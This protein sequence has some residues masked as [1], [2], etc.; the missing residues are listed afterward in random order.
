MEK[1]VW[2]LV[3]S[4]LAI[5]S[6]SVDSYFD[7]MKAEREYMIHIVNPTDSLIAYECGF[8]VQLK[9]GYNDNV[10]IAKFMNK[11]ID[12]VEIRYISYYWVDGGYGVELVDVSL[13]P[14]LLNSGESGKVLGTFHVDNGE[15]GLIY[16][17]FEAYWANGSALIS[18][19]FCPVNISIVHKETAWAIPEYCNED[20]NCKCWKNDID[21]CI[22]WGRYFYYRGGD[23][24]VPVYAG[25]HNL[26]GYLTISAEDETEFC[27][28]L[29]Y[30][31]DE[32]HLYFG[33]TEPPEAPGEFLI[34]AKNVRSDTY[35]VTLSG[36][37]GWVAAHASV[38]FD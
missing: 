20:E 27:Y 30:T 29:K 37:E 38:F 21:R 10:E 9:E 14:L 25:Q 2:F 4:V 1:A 16:F 33:K 7:T 12:N 26:V 8:D 24:N 13:D 35:C 3:L 31:I 22:G 32:I 6:V 15:D 28:N 23:L 34:K 5:A 18:T 11:L 19:E 36:N 17:V